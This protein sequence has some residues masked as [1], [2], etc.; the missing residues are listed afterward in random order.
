[1]WSNTG[2]S[3]HKVSKSIHHLLRYQNVQ[4]YTGPK[5]C[6]GSQKSSNHERFFQILRISYVS[7]GF[8][9]KNN[10]FLISSLHSRC[11]FWCTFH[12]FLVPTLAY[13]SLG[14][15]NFST[16]KVQLKQ[17]IDWESIKFIEL[18]PSSR[19]SSPLYWHQK[20]RMQTSLSLVLHLRS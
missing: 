12:T 1:M 17:L 13:P 11:T 6:C 19:I 5:V 7:V 16:L 2:K 9:S 18:L 8:W 14:E 10:F 4:N 20:W 3:L 15:K